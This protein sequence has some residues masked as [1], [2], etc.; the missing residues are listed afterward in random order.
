MRPAAGFNPKQK[1]ER[2]STNEK[3]S[4]DLVIFGALIAFVAILWMMLRWFD[5]IPKSCNRVGPATN[6]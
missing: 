6:E 1:L 2:K 3:I 5:S 4:R